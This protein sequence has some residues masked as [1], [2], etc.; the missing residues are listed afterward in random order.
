MKINPFVEWTF[1]IKINKY[2]FFKKKTTL[3]LLTYIA[4]KLSDSKLYLQLIMEKCSSKYIDCSDRRKNL[5]NIF[6]SNL[7]FH[8]PTPTLRLDIPP[9]T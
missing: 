2:F 8:H 6:I 1:F 7:G 5:L 3:S 4:C 9:E